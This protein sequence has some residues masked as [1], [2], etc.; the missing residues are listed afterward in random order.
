M[1]N[2]AINRN[3]LLPI[4]LAMKLECPNCK[5]IF[6]VD[7]NHYAALVAQVKNTEFEAEIKRRLAELD[8]KH[9]S[10][11]EVLRLRLEADNKQ[12]IADKEKALASLTSEIERLKAAL[13]GHEATKRVELADADLA[14]EREI[15]KVTESKNREIADLKSRLDIIDK[16]HEIKILEA[17]NSSKDEISQL[18]RT[19]TELNAQLTNQQIAARNSELELRKHNEILLKNKDEEIERLK[20]MKSRLSTKML[21]ETLEQHCQTAFN[22]ARAYGQF[23]SAYFEKDNDASGGTKGDF[24]FRDYIGDKE[25]LSIMFEMKTEDDRTATKHRNEDFFAK[26][27]KDRN[28]KHCEY[29]VLVS[30]LEADNELYNEGIVDVSY[31]YEKMFVVRPQFFMSIISLLSRAAK[32]N[33]ETIISLRNELEV[34]KVQN[35][36][37]TTFEARRDKFVETFKKHVDAH[38]K[39]HESAIE[40]I[41][42]A[43]EA[44]EKQAEN[45]RKVKIMFEQSRKKLENANDVAENDFTIRKLTYG[46]PTMRAKFAE[47]RAN[48]SRTDNNAET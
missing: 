16:E 42:K 15:A 8:D 44:A 1:V 47:I 48:A 39:K 26:L 14:R 6:E 4:I 18:N 17:K 11:E 7:E 33:A 3:I 20:D 30:T 5:T 10:E 43:I 24:I 37:I 31:R 22:R 32:R 27:D 34:A 40:S 21:G 35:I 12:K 46:N 2:F 28:D 25:C 38:L 41:D 45:L 9:K 23:Q 19:I 36:D 29:A 13:A